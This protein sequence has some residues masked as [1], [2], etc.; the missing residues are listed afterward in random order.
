MKR[1]ELSIV[2]HQSCVGTIFETFI[3]SEGRVSQHS[4]LHHT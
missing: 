2:E 3:R 1:T 4:K